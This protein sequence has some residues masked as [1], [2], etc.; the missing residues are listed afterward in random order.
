[1]EIEIYPNNKAKLNFIH[2]ANGKH[3]D[4]KELIIA[5][6]PAFQTAFNKFKAN[7]V[8]YTAEQKSAAASY[9]TLD[10]TNSKQVLAKI[11]ANVAGVIYVCDSEKQY[12]LINLKI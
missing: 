2:R 7:I 5:S 11:E 12:K 1:M 3:I 4:D 9:F 10:K 8:A 6:T